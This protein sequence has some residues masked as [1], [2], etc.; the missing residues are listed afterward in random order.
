MGRDGKVIQRTWNALSWGA[1][2][3]TAF[4]AACGETSRRPD[5]QLVEAGEAGQG[6]G[7]TTHAG[8]TTA[9][10]SVAGGTTSAGGAGDLNG[11]AGETDPGAGAGEGGAPAVTRT[12]TLRILDSIPWPL[13][14]VTV[15][16]QG[17]KYL[18][19]ADGLVSV[20]APLGAYDVIIDDRAAE[21]YGAGVH[22]YQGVT[23]D[24]ATF[25]LP[26][27][28]A[29]QF[30][31]ASSGSG[32]LIGTFPNDA[33][34]DIDFF[35]TSGGP[36]GAGTP[37][38]TG[39]AFTLSSVWYADVS[40]DG[41]LMALL[42]T[43]D[44]DERP[45]AYWYG[46]APITWGPSKPFTKDIT[47]SA[48]ST[49]DVTYSVSGPDGSVIGKQI[50]LGAFQLVAEPPEQTPLTLPKSL[51]YSGGALDPELVVTFAKTAEL[52]TPRATLV[53]PLTDATT[54]ATVS[55]TNFV[56]L[57]EPADG[58][59]GVRDTTHFTFTDYPNSCKEVSISTGDYTATIHTTSAD[60]VPP[61]LSAL[62]MGWRGGRKGEFYVRAMAPCTSLDSLLS[63]QTDP[64]AQT[65][66]FSTP[67]GNFT[68]AK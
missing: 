46:S 26:R 55:L 35:T 41:D 13:E 43:L 57:I 59:L 15:V 45:D 28:Y 38:M 67:R 19:D 33:K 16:V 39:N 68:T 2:C 11:G 52:V 27:D 8:G 9:G 53:Q 7:S 40:A 49:R 64:A 54:S 30:P 56:E 22:V 21:E 47:V 60:V 66:F 32:H 5:P 61:D 37:K 51:T 63:S 25:R 42:W 58:A 29:D 14:G 17:R 62:E 6:G 18:S 50:R 34:S 12:V 3:A 31:P 44:S 4:V 48:A 36:V 65:R 20:E 1:A 10:G 23:L 24:L